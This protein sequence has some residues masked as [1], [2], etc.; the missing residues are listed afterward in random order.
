MS[1]A[2]ETGRSPSTWSPRPVD[3]SAGAL[4]WAPLFI[5]IFSINSAVVMLAWFLLKLLS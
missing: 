3:A 1:E 2:I 4:R 5:L